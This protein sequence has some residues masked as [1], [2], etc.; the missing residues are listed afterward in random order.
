MG[1]L[2][3]YD[4]LRGSSKYRF[5]GP[6]KG[7]LVFAASVW[8]SYRKGNMQHKAEKLALVEQL[9]K[10]FP[11]A[12]IPDIMGYINAPP[13]EEDAAL[14]KLYQQGLKTIEVSRKPFDGNI[15]YATKTLLA[16]D[17]LNEDK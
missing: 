1:P 8:G 7:I 4:V 16:L 10:Q 17:K 6:L 15:E 5:L 14:T 2:F 3:V 13:W 12:D 9:R 11:H